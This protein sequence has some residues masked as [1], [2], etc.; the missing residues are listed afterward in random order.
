MTGLFPLRIQA[1]AVAVLA[2]C[3]AA[4]LLLAPPPSPPPSADAPGRW[5]PASPAAGNGTVRWADAAV[6]TGVD[7]PFSPRPLLEG[8]SWAGSAG[9]GPESA[10]VVSPPAPFPPDSGLP[11]RGER[12]VIGSGW[13]WL[14]QDVAEREAHRRRRPALSPTERLWREAWGTHDSHDGGADWLS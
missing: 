6:L 13:G 5:M 3:G 2:G 7:L 14:Q 8:R 11:R 4:R 9:R 12:E 10:L 1:L